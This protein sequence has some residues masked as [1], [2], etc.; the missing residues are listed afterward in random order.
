[1]SVVDMSHETD[2]AR[3]AGQPRGRPRRRP[4]VLFLSC[5]LPWPPISGG[6]RRELELIER[7]SEE[8]EI[9]LVAVSK[10]PEQDLENLAALAGSCR[11]VEVFAAQS[12]ADGVDPA[13]APFAVRRH[14]CAAA[15]ARVAEILTAQPV[16]LIHVEGFY[17][18]QHVP[19]RPPAPVLLVEQ[20]VE[21]ELERQRA[22]AG[23]SGVT[24]LDRFTQCV[25][26]HEAEL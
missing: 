24:R 3:A 12:G 26:T 9:H 16:E 18:M 21:Y 20:N 23:A 15:S 7:V 13:D 8:F 1:M 25:R 6:R 22:A 10:T 19:E 4:R 14:R 2:G 11:Q 17:L 5:H